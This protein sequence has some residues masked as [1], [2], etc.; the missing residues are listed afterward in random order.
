M[1]ACKP[2]YVR[3]LALSH[4]D[5]LRDIPLAC[6]HH[7]HSLRYFRLE[8]RLAWSVH[9]VLGHQDELDTWKV[10]ELVPGPRIGISGQGENAELSRRCV[11]LS[12]C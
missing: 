3:R 8:E 5:L 12:E 10:P 11:V 9:V 4:I 2:Y 7:I 6:E 1:P